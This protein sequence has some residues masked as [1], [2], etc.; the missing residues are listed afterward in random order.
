MGP[1]DLSLN[2]SGTVS[3]EETAVFALRCSESKCP[4]TDS[5][6]DIIMK[7]KEKGQ[8]IS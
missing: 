1:Q 3:T 6:L 8:N 4:K 2:L 5:G 7:S